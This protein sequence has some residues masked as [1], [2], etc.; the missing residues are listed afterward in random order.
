MQEMD[1]KT[2]EMLAA[3]RAEMRA[4]KWLKKHPTATVKQV[5]GHIRE[6]LVIARQMMGIQ[7]R[8]HL[9]IPN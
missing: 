8:H 9:S 5:P 3:E 7:A 4:L 1:Q 2:Q 6:K